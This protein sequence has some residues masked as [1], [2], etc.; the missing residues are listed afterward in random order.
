[1]QPNISVLSDMFFD[2]NTT[3]EM[4]LNRFPLFANKIKVL[5]NA[6]PEQDLIS[7]SKH[8]T[9]KQN[10]KRSLLYLDSH[11]VIVP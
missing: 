9:T 5:A 11:T 10:Y 7:L 1:M 4:L 8:N 3:R 6:Y 2:K